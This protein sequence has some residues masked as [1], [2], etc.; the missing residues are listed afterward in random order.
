MDIGEVVIMLGFVYGEEGEFYLRLNVVC[1]REKFEDG[2]NRIKK[3]MDYIVK[4]IL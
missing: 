2:L 1:L 4:R 3:I